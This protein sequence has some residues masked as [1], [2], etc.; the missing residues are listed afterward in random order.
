MTRVMKSP[1]VAVP[2]GVVV[3]TI[4]PA[5]ALNDD[6]SRVDFELVL[7]PSKAPIWGTMN[8]PITTNVIIHAA[9]RTPCF[10][11]CNCRQ[12][13]P[14]RRISLA[15]IFTECSLLYYTMRHH[16][17]TTCNGCLSLP[18]LVR[19]PHTCYTGSEFRD[20]KNL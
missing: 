14:N 8:K 9:I 15:F 11:H 2:S 20:M 17:L 6:C 1:L 4:A 7:F 19:L 13:S 18:P 3:R 5:D 10:F 12:N 16:Y